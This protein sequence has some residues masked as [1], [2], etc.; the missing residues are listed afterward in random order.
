MSGME[1][2]KSFPLEVY[3]NYAKESDFPLLPGKGKNHCV[4]LGNTK[5]LWGPFI[6]S[7]DKSS[8]QEHPINEFCFGLIH[9]KLKKNDLPVLDVRF[10]D[11]KKEKFVNFQKICHLSGLAYLNE[12][13]HLCVHGNYNLNLVFS[14]SLA[15]FGPWIALRA[16]I[17]F[18]FILPDF[19][20]SNDAQINPFPEGDVK[21]R[22]QMEKFYQLLKKEHTKSEINDVLLEVR[23]IAGIV[24]IFTPFELFFIVQKGEFLTNINEIK[25]SPEQI[26]YHYTKDK[27]ILFNAP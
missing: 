9:Q 15:E 22:Q 27:Q 25:Y 23:N 18:D 14:S 20:Y 1:L 19:K 26:S 12:N 2:F 10:P 5:R 6:Q 21:L 11:D 24:S 16:V 13:C 17:V 4:L 8:M 7:L 3:N